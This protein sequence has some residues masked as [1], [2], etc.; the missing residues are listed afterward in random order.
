MLTIQPVRKQIIQHLFRKRRRPL[1]VNLVLILIFAVKYLIMNITT[2]GGGVH[3]SIRT[4][5]APNQATISIHSAERIH[6]Q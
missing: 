1:T 6:N 5:A 3:M 4:P 2:S